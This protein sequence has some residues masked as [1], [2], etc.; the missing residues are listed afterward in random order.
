M[1]ATVHLRDRRQI[2]LPADIVAAAGLRTDDPLQISWSH[3]AI[4]MVP[5]LA[6]RQ[7]P[8]AMSRF[9]GEAKGLYG[10]SPAVPCPACSCCKPAPK[11]S[12]T[13]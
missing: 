7:A 1:S 6:P 13:A 10:T 4:V 5:S 8:R 3:G 9:L 12:S 11:A 2:T